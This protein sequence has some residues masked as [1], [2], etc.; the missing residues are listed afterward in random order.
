MQFM[1]HAGAAKKA[2]ISILCRL[3]TVV[4]AVEIVLVALALIAARNPAQPALLYAAAAVP[5]GLVLFS[6]FVLM[7]FRDPEPRPPTDPRLVVSPAYGKVDFV[8]EAIEPEFMGGRCRRVSIFLSIFDPHVQHAPVSGTVGLLK[9]QPGKFICA[10]RTEAAT[11]NEN[12]LIGFDPKDSVGRKIAVRLVAGVLARRIVPW[13]KPGDEVACG[14]RISL[15]RFGSRVELY[16]PMSSKINVGPGQK[17]A[18]GRTVIA[19]LE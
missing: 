8:G 6:G 14:D 4:A 18:G 19:Q 1:K 3:F 2:A 7:F 5:A 13:I 16:L 10:L 9:H 17:V 12:V 15:I 11:A